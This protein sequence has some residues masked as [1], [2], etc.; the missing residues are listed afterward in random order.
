MTQS[1]FYSSTSGTMTLVGA[2]NGS[3][4]T[5]VVDTVTG[6]PGTTPYTIIIDPGSASMEICEVTAVG[7]TTLTVTRGV[8]GTSG[9]SHSNGATIRHGFSARDFDDSRAHEV[10]TSAHG[11]TGSVVGTSDTQVLTNKDLS[12]ATNTF[13]ATLATLTGTQT[14]THKDLSDATNVFPTSLVTLTGTQTLT[15]KTITGGTVNPTTL[16]KGGINVPTISE[17]ATLTNKTISGSS[18]TLSNIPQSAVTSL[19]T[20]L[21]DHE[22]RIQLLETDTGW[23]TNAGFTA[24]SGF[25]IT[26]QVTRKTQTMVSV[27]LNMTSTNAISAGNIGNTNI[28]NIPASWTPAQSNGHIGGGPSGPG[29][30]AYASVGGAIIM[31]SL[32]QNIAAGSTFNVF[33][34]WML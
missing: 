26:G 21:S 25:T 4:T 33:G 2:I 27:Q 19:V 18:N 23:V 24:A 28:A 1:R 11:V 13:P 10:D 6:L 32:D 15:N 34:V 17:T 31:T 9:Q 16:Q 7:G 14:L 20:D 5:V 22:S 30:T 8:D 3:T 29:F 12:S